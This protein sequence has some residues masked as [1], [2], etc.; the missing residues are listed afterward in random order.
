MW[1][2]V[3]FLVAFPIRCYRFVEPV[4]FSGEGW[5]NPFLAESLFWSR[6]NF[7]IHS[8][9]WGGFTNG[10]NDPPTIDN[11]YRQLG[12][13]YIGISDYQKVNPASFVPL[14]EHGWNVG[15]V[16]QLAFAPKA[17]VWWDVPLGQS[18]S[19]KQT[20][21]EKLSEVSALVALAHPF[22]NP[23]QTYTEKELRY[24]GGFVA[25]EVLNR[26]GDSVKEWDAILSSGHYATILASDNVHDVRNKHQ[27]ASR[28]TELAIAPGASLS[29]VLEAIQAGKTVGYKNHTSEPILPGSYPKLKSV[30]LA[31]RQLRLELDRVVDT[32][33]VIG[34]GGSRRLEVY[35][36]AK[37]VYDI[38]PEDTYLRIEAHTARVSL[39]SSPLVRGEPKRRAVP[40][41]DWPRTW[42]W[43]GLVLTLALGFLLGRFWR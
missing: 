9:T 16:H 3:F 13:A 42:L 4:V 31:A 38:R 12:Y 24:L 30:R 22:F 36:T 11:A 20:V 35:H 2:I 1:A 19:A 26:Y 34:Q 28:W 27:L 40:P 17:I 5:Y 25:V 21:L 41:V 43:R 23:Y 7:H 14:Y 10:Y 39:Y 32:L 15:K 8:R 6:A 33:R 18:L 29:A 37:V